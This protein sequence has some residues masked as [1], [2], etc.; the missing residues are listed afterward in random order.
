M[1]KKTVIQKFETHRT[2]FN[3]ITYINSIQYIQ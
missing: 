3:S 2:A 1:N